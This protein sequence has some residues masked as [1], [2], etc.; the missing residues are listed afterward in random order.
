[1]ST[2]EIT[3]SP[4]QL[5]AAKAY[6]LDPWMNAKPEPEVIDGGRVEIQYHPG[7]KSYCLRVTVGEHY[8]TTWCT[9]REL[10]HAKRQAEQ[11]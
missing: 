11:E 1:M 7:K 9:E 4:E 10:A 5:A 2:I 8:E 3:F 6:G